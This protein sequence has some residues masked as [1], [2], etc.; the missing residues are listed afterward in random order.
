MKIN[1]SSPIVFNIQNHI[2]GNFQEAPCS[3]MNV[4]VPSRI[5]KYVIEP[6]A[7]RTKSRR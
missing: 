7:L 6:D 3:D 1:I 5:V 2:E 4:T